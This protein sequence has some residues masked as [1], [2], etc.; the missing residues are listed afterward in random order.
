MENVTQNNNLLKSNKTKSISKLVI[1]S[2]VLG[3][4]SV[5]CEVVSFGFAWLFIDSFIF[6]PIAG[7]LMGIIAII[8]GI[9]ILWTI[10]VID[11]TGK[12]QFR[13]MW[14]AIV[15]II[16]GLLSVLSIVFLY[17]LF[18]FGPF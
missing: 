4:L 15:S 17:F 8:L 3:I 13:D 1:V 6:L 7:L 5:V 18:Q 10:T 2:L 16:L 14:V 9:I 12:E 11:K